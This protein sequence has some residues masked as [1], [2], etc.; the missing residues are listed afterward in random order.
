MASST[1]P[2][3]GESKPIRLRNRRPELLGREVSPEDLV[4]AFL[5]PVRTQPVLVHIRVSPLGQ[6]ILVET[7]RDG[8]GSWWPAHPATRFAWP[9]DW[10]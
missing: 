10:L 8:D 1:T 9:E 7:R 4:Y 6:G 3:L 5:P 2:Q